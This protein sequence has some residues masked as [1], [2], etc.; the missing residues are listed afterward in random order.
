MNVCMC[1]LL[2]AFSI[3]RALTVSPDHESEG[4]GGGVGERTAVAG[5][6]IY[7]LGRSITNLDLSEVTNKSRK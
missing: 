3:R 2:A 1:D 5:K 7:T 6:R 4:R